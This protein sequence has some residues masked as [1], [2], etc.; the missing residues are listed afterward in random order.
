[1]ATAI[2]VA[3]RALKLI[4][5]QAADAPLQADEYA[6]FYSAM[7]DYM[8]DLKGQGTDLGYTAVSAGSD[9]ITIPDECIRGLIGNMAVEVAPDYEKEITPALNR[10]ADNGL[11]TMRRIG[12]KR[13]QVAYP[14][15]LPR[16]SGRDWNT[17]NDFAFYGQQARARLTLTNNNLATTIAAVDTPVRINGQWVSVEA[18]NYL[19][20]ITGRLTNSSN[21]AIDYDFKATLEVTGGS[22]CTLHLYENG[23]ESLKTVSGVANGSDIFLAHTSTLLPNEFLEIW[24]EN[25]TDDTDLTVRDCQ[26]VVS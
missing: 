16:G 18:M 21:L 6:D 1:M 8:A 5:V 20:N 24:I 19:G 4:L 2:Y 12:R 22:D 10:M 9:L 13:T 14:P 17:Y 26:M 3:E 25:D 11:K 7:N 15:T 23:N